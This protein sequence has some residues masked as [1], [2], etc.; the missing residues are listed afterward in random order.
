MSDAVSREAVEEYLRNNPH[1]IQEWVLKNVG[2][3]ELEEWLNG[4][5]LS[6]LEEKNQFSVDRMQNQRNSITT[7][8]FRDLVE[9]KRKLPSTYSTRTKE[10]LLE[11][12]QMELFMELIRDIT[13]ELD[14]NVLCHKILL[15]VSILTHSDR[16]SLFLVRGSGDKK[17]LVSKLFDV[18]EDS[19]LQESLHGEGTEIRVP[20][21][22]GIAGAVAESR[23]PINIKNAYE[24]STCP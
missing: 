2:K 11:M 13:N 24:V 10:E 3:S 4:D 6:S 15:N 7:N 1:F 14:V 18:T 21:G 9:G 22:V 20:F 16:G 12:S 17:T 23:T 5:Q 8:M 19:S